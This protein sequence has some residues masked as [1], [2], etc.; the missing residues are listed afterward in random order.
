MPLAITNVLSA[1]KWKRVF[2][3]LL[4]TRTDSPLIVYV[5]FFLR[6]LPPASRV[7]LFQSSVPAIILLPPVIRCVTVWVI[8]SA[9]WSIADTDSLTVLNSC[10]VLPRS[11]EMVVVVSSRLLT[12][13]L[14]LSAF[15]LMLETSSFRLFTVAVVA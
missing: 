9:F 7:A 8:L 4:V 1:P 12:L 14:M 10:F 15:W 2:C 5:P 11:L 3:A 13:V 6:S